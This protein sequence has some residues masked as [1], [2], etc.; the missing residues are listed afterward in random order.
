[1]RV[2]AQV[3]EENPL[4]D[5]SYD[6]DS[7]PAP[8]RRQRSRQRAGRGASPG[9]KS[10]APEAVSIAW[11][12]LGLDP[13]TAAEADVNKAFRQLARECHPDLHPGD[14]AAARRFRALRQ[15]TDLCLADIADRTGR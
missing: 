13:E 5:E 8:R 2:G 15:S 9:V 4:D 7:E 6:P 3:A 14:T 1:M 12:V 11:E 10:P